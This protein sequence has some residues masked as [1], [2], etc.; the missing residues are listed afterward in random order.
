MRGTFRSERKELP[1]PRTV[2]YKFQV[3]KLVRR[4]QYRSHVFGFLVFKIPAVKMNYD[5]I[6]I[7]RRFRL[8]TG[9]RRRECM[10]GR[11]CQMTYVSSVRLYDNV[12]NTA[13]SLKTFF[14]KCF[15]D[16]FII[17]RSVSYFREWNAYTWKGCIVSWV[18]HFITH[19]NI[20]IY[21]YVSLR[22]YLSIYHT[23]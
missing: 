3:G 14:D 6:I 19:N 9:M 8:G 7:L 21:L 12:S 23:I 20:S 17:H 11:S 10:F 15:S 18:V 5:A 13:V 4:H 16:Q 22:I 1:V 2:V